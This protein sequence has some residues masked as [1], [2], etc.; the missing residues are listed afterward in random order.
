MSELHWA[1]AA[2]IP[3]HFMLQ[4]RK[5]QIQTQNIFLMT[6]YTSKPPPSSSYLTV[7]IKRALKKNNKKKQS[8]VARRVW[9]LSK[10]FEQIS[11]KSASAWL[12]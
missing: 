5:V 8:T 4:V 10:E 2:K 11:Y 12:G 9:N 7:I 6:H 3:L 1:V